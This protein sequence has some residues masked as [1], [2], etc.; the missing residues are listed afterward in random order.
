MTLINC[1]V[2]LILKATREVDP[3]AN[4]AVAGINNPANATFKGT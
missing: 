4:P 3:G 1:E 2:S